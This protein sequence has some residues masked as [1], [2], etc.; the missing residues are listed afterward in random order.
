MSA[1]A[2]GPALPDSRRFGV[3]AVIIADALDGQEI[4]VLNG[5]GLG[6]RWALVSDPDTHAAL[7]SAIARRLSA[8]AT[9][10]HIALTTRPVAD[11]Q[12][13]AMIERA[14]T[15]CDALIAVGSGTIND[16]CKLAAARLARPY[17][18]FATAPSMNGFVSANAA[19]RMGGH[20][21]TVAA[22]TPRAAFFD[23][24]VLANAPARM[25]RSGL[26]DSV[27]R[28]TAQADWLLSHY[29]VGTNYSSEPFDMLAAFEADL[30]DRAE[31]LVHRD[32]AAMQTLVST[33]VVSGFGMSL[34]GTSEPASQGEHLISHTF[35]ILHKSA[36]ALHGEQ[37]GVATLTMSQL[38]HRW[39]EHPD[40]PQVRSTPSPD[41]VLSFFGP[42]AGT[43]IARDY[44][45]KQH[46][47]SAA[48]AG[49]R[50]ATLW[51]T[52][53]SHIVPTLVPT[54]RIRATL[55]KAQC[56]MLPA[57]LHWDDELYASV[58]RFARTIRNRVTFLDLA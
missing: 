22:T 4:G 56:P 42:D 11:E 26:G 38:Q 16:L 48:S 20:K 18:V 17:V 12:T 27:C 30:F 8:I 9:I 2:T 31:G 23:L 35:E 28:T 46:A 49:G 19:L 15:S 6:H 5:L 52:A 40:P 58:V 44:A 45:A 55:A 51:G 53:V 3:D 37:V 14:A 32:L 39:I 54:S 7:G 25:I 29:L 21:C 33:L 10:E 13:L 36:D 47:L 1:A 24:G 34:V 41:E 43:R 57:D 50:W